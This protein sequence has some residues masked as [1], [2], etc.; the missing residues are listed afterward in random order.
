M[1]YPTRTAALTC[2]LITACSAPDRDAVQTPDTVRDSAAAPSAPAA[3]RVTDLAL[4]RFRAF[5]W[6]AGDTIW[7]IARG[8]LAFVTT[9]GDTA[10]LPWTA[11]DVQTGFDGHVTWTD[12]EGIR[13]RSA[14]GERSILIPADASPIAEGGS[15]TLLHAQ[16]ANRA[17]VTW[18][19]EGSVGMAVLDAGVL[20]A[21]PAA[22]PGLAST[23]AHW[24][25]DRRV[26]V[27]STRWSPRSGPAAH[28]ESGYRADL[29]LIDAAGDTDR[30]LT[31]ARDGEFF[32][33][34]GLLAPGSL[35][36]GIR[37]P[38]GS[39][40]RHVTLELATGAL[41]P[42][43]LPPGR[44]RAAHGVVALLRPASDP[45]AGGEPAWTLELFEGD[46]R[47]GPLLPLRGYD[48]RLLWHPSARRL[49]VAQDSE[50]AG[51]RTWL[52]HSPG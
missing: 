29:V 23:G 16:T 45:A 19:G 50:T 34:E 39:P 37:S 43:N 32:T 14:A 17:W 40:G 51:Y 44:A 3:W 47:S 8:R 5:G 35:L 13:Q 42:T 27:G 6:G 49:I 52:I 11:W 20:R 15:P 22:A 48:I 2:M 41:T 38:S 21:L 36:A 18:T 33:P 4:P 9:S 10:T 31:D 7:G 26:V 46:V 28:R 1:H 24:V 12:D 30:T 25:D